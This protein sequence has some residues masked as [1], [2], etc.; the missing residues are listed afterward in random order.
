METPTVLVVDDHEVVRKGLI[1]LL[2][3]S[4]LQV[5]G[6]AATAEE[7]IRLVKRQRPSVVLLDVRLGDAD[8]LDPAEDV[9]VG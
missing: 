1:S 9:L 4:S 8:G 7:A 5:C 3:G 2:A 6:E